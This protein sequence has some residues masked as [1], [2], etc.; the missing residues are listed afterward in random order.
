MRYL[1]EIYIPRS[2]ILAGKL[3]FTSVDTRTLRVTGLSY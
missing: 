1:M 2:F 3:G